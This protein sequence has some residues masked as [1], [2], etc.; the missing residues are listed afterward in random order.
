[1]YGRPPAHRLNHVWFP[2]SVD[3]P[4]VESNTKL[5]TMKPSKDKPDLPMK[6]EI[7][8]RAL[9]I[10]KSALDSRAGLK[11]VSGAGR[12]PGGSDATL[13]VVP[14][15]KSDL[16]R[17]VLKIE[18]VRF[19][20]PARLRTIVSRMLD[21]VPSTSTKV[22]LAVPYMSPEAA[23][24]C[25][26]AGALFIDLCGNRYLDL[27]PWLLIDVSGHPN[28]FQRH[29]IS[30][31]F[32]RKGSRVTRALL[33]RREPPWSQKELSRTVGL[34]EGYTSKIVGALEREGIVRRRSSIEVIAP[35]ELL[36]AWRMRSKIGLGDR[37]PAYFWGRAR[38]AAEHLL[39]QQ[40]ATI[41]DLRFA[42]TGPSAAWELAP[43]ADYRISGLYISRPLT[44]EELARH[45]IKLVDEGENLWLVVP[46]DEGVFQFG[47]RTVGR[48]GR[49]PFFYEWDPDGT[50]VRSG[51]KNGVGLAEVGIP[52]VSAVQTYI[53]LWSFPGRSREAAEELKRKLIPGGPGARLRQLGRL[54]EGLTGGARSAPQSQAAPGDLAGLRGV[55]QPAGAARAERARGRVA[56]CH[57][58][59]PTGAGP[60]GLPLHHRG[61]GPGHEHG[62][63]PLAAGGD[64]AGAGERPVHRR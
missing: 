15:F 52:V 13:E 54:Q 55:P 19:A 35:D 63:V 23:S 47:S 5:E 64:P 1:M 39:A 4:N 11:R 17:Q 7:L 57:G 22:L 49:G 9:Q 28:Q 25:R 6:D 14:S 33:G 34:S 2:F 12:R 59:A 50:V 24:V 38:P 8:L 45:E 58:A 20:S 37:T 51:E 10:L 16:D 41:P 44:E 27:P 29:H 42:F 46:K 18:S 43:H 60:G 62:G 61:R 21:E 30:G 32:S 3:F 40:L 48:P 31:A 56:G 36:E 53:D 26:Q